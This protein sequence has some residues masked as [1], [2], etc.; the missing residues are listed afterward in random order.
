[1][2]NLPRFVRTLLTDFLF[3]LVHVVIKVNCPNINIKTI[4]ATFL[5]FIFYVFLKAPAS[6]V[7]ISLLSLAM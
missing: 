3:I 7:T 6:I 1:M 2:R 4:N 5:S